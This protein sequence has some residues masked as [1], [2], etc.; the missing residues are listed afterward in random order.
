MVDPALNLDTE[1]F[2]L[3]C[4]LLV[5]QVGGRSI[6]VPAQGVDDEVPVYICS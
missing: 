3:V 6:Q 4:C 1:H 5:G 2:Q